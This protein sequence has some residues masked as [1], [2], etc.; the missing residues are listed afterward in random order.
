MVQKPSANG[1]DARDA[2]CRFDPWAGKTPW[3]SKWQPASGFLPGKSHG[4]R[5]LA[6]YSLRGLKDLDM[7]EQLSTHA[8][9]KALCK[10][11]VRTKL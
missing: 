5:N 4:Q 1:G 3:R 11:K 10:K 8:S 6:G 7:M 2:G 9:E